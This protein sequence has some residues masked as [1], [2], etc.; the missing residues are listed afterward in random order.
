M[1]FLLIISALTSLLRYARL[2][3]SSIISLKLVAIINNS[4]S[5]IIERL[6]G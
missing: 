1:L 3:S 5:S 2:A 4:I 6:T